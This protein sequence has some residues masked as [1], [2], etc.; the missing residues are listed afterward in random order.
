MPF[1]TDQ[2]GREIYLKQTPQRIVS[3]VPSQPELLFVP[4]ANKRYI[5]YTDFFQHYNTLSEVDKQS[6]KPKLEKLKEQYLKSIHK[7]RLFS[8]L[9][10]L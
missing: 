4:K 6:A 8:S 3:L 1:Y 2:L 5:A 7:R 10:P 9:F